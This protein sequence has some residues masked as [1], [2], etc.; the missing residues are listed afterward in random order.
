MKNLCT[1][2]CQDTEYTPT[3]AY[4]RK[5]ESGVLSFRTTM[6][7][8]SFGNGKSGH[9]HTGD[10]KESEQAKAKL[11]RRGA[12]IAFVQLNAE[13][14]PRVFNLIPKMWEYIAGGVISTFVGKCIVF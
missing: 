7:S 1:F 3:F 2:L 5:T 4:S 13:F 8:D 10:T 9:G 14:G 6:P 12:Q 11:C